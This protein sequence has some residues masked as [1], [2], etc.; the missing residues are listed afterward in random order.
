M[1]LTTVVNKMSIKLRA[2]GLFF[3]NLFCLLNLSFDGNEY[4]TSNSILMLNVLKM[5]ICDLSISVSSYSKGFIISAYKE[6]FVIFPR[7]SLF[8]QYSMFFSVIFLTFFSVE[9]FAL[10]IVQ[11]S[12]I[13]SFMN[14]TLRMT[15][16][17]NHM[18]H[19]RWLAGTKTAFLST[20]FVVVS[21]LRFFA[22]MKL[23][24]ASMLVYFVL[25]FPS[26][27]VFAFVNFVNNT[28]AYFVALLKQIQSD[29]I[30]NLNSKEKLFA[31]ISKQHFE[32]YRLVDNFNVSF[33]L[34][35][36]LLTCSLTIISV[37]GVCIQ[38]M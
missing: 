25:I 23:S 10:Q 31:K 7:F 21:T 12:K 37:F 18:R 14:E 29:L 28:E 26:C 36:T 16:E 4:K 13:E 8:T 11:R 15:L 9:L 24:F 38:K 22:M 19:F 5:F 3:Y 17:A 2:F 32:I 1:E 27:I 35:L 33:G 6:D 30:S 20:F 34:Q